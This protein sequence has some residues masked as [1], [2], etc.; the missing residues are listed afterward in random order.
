MEYY[1]AIP[2]GSGAQTGSSQTSGQDNAQR[3][4]GICLVL[5]SLP[6]KRFQGSS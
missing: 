4:K 3:E 1:S 6:A 5:Q 2:D